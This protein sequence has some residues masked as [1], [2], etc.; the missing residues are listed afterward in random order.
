MVRHLRC[1]LQ[2]AAVLEIRR[3]PRR[4]ETVIVKVGRDAGRI[5]AP[6]DHY[7]SIGLGQGGARYSE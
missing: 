2:R 6:A 4:S 5:C 1:L 3:D 7:I